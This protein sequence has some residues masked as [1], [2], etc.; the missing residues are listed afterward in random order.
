M[1]HR[2]LVLSVDAG[3]AVLAPA[4]DSNRLDLGNRGW[5]VL[6]LPLFRAL[7]SEDCRVPSFWPVFCMYGPHASA[8]KLPGL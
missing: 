6:V 4:V 8:A 1:G 7:G 3:M 5:C 2:G